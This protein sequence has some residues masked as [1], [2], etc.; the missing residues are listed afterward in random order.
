MRLFHSLR[1]YRWS[2]GRGWEQD[3]P[4]RKSG[5]LW[6]WNRAGVA[7]QR[8]AR[9]L[10]RRFGGDVGGVIPDPI[11][12]SVV[13][14]S[15][16]DGT[17]RETAWESRTPPELMLETPLLRKRGFFFGACSVGRRLLAPR[18]T[19]D[20]VPHVWWGIRLLSF[21]DGAGI[22]AV[23]RC[24][25]WSSASLRLACFLGHPA[26]VVAGVGRGCNRR[27]W[28]NWRVAVAAAVGSGGD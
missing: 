21:R 11:P 20:A 5:R 6:Q 17:A 7:R 4:D 1:S 27:R 22:I 2:R 15:R 23:A 14:P 24:S 19:T 28:R 3:P 25:S 18:P 16:A 13:K 10:S 26:S 8:E 12:N 9:M